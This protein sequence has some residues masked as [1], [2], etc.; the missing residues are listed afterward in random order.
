MIAQ[1]DGTTNDFN[2]KLF[3]VSGFPTLYFVPSATHQPVAYEG[4]RSAA[5]ILSFIRQKASTPLP[6]QVVDD[7][8]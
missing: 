8:L 1:L 2:K 6:A 4:E 7:E 5:A 3:P